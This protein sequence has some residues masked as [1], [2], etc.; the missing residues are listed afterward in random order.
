MLKFYISSA[1]PHCEIN[2]YLLTYLERELKGIEGIL[3][4]DTPDSADIIIIGTCVVDA[5]NENISRETLINL[6]KRYP[7]KRIFVAGCLSNFDPHFIKANKFDVFDKSKILAECYRKN[8]ERIPMVSL[9]NRYC[10]K[11]I[12]RNENYFLSRR[13]NIFYINISE[14][15]TN[16]C[17]YCAIKIAKGDI[18]SIPIESIIE[19]LEENKNLIAGNFICLLADDC[20]SFGIDNKESFPEL[21]IKI[22]KKISCEYKL[23]IHY[24]FPLHFLNQFKMIPAEIWKR[25][26]YINIPLQSC[27]DRILK[28]MNR[29]YSVSDVLDAINSIKK[30]NPGIKLETHIIYGFPTESIDEFKESFHLVSV[31]DRI[32]FS[33]YSDRKGTRA[34][35]IKGRIS[36]NEKI[37]R[38]VLILKEQEKYKQ[39]RITE[40]DIFKK[41]LTRIK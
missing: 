32:I 6:R 27:S 33:C 5:T 16:A 26:H 23:I 11:E 41:S 21:L 24:W 14:G 1:N 7:S 30:I 40:S 35:H 12:L 39:I 13:E 28:L 22:K 20:G 8:V 19:Q 31:F 2:S 9:L 18:R 4:T 37:E 36:E 10:D 17:S 34:S 15:C 29:N 3:E 38:T 25:I